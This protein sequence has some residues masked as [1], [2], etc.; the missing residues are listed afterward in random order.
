M[1]NVRDARFWLQKRRV[2]ESKYLEELSQSKRTTVGH[3]T[4]IHGVASPY[5][6]GVPIQL[7]GTGIVINL[8]GTGSGAVP[9]DLKPD[10]TKSL[11]RDA[12]FTPSEVKNLYKSKNAAAVQVL[13][14]LDRPY[15][16]GDHLDA[17]LRILDGS[18]SLEGGVLLPVSLFMIA[19]KPT[20]AKSPTPGQF[21]PAK[22]FAEASGLVTADLFV[23]KA[24]KDSL[25][26][27]ITIVE[28][29]T[30]LLDNWDF[31]ALVPADNDGRFSL[32][33]ELLFNGVFSA[34]SDPAVTRFHDS[35]VIKLRIP[36][37]Y[38]DD[39]NRFY[40]V[41]NLM[42]AKAT[43]SWYKQDR[44]KKL[45][46]ELRSK[47]VQTRYLAA[48]GLVGMQAP[49]VGVLEKAL[50]DP[51]PD[52]RLEVAGAL[53]PLGQLS[54]FEPLKAIAEGSDLGRKI[55]A[56][57]ILGRLGAPAAAP[58]IEKFLDD[59]NP[60]VVYSAAR[61]LGRIGSSARVVV[62]K[63][64]LWNLN[65]APQVEKTAVL[66]GCKA[67]R[68]ILL[69]GEPAV[70]GQAR[71][72]I[73]FMTVTHESGNTELFYEQRLPDG[74]ILRASS[75]ANVQSLVETFSK[76]GASFSQTARLISSLVQKGA[77]SAVTDSYMD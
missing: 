8:K 47:D 15:R 59:P 77:V 50:S 56:I 39:W 16:T 22:L 55:S 11:V 40:F 10:L 53:A 28:Q 24:V 33:L 3:E 54:I 7:I 14:F 42:D 21:V 6:T 34:G 17:T 25:P 76:A 74:R 32:Y 26:P 66:F 30:K 44:L 20:T 73:G 31:F 58:F 37:P 4:A 35:P 18:T 72:T 23:P 36:D 46:Q 69:M 71:E 57:Y 9:D 13:A 43:S 48:C 63:G 2:P 19:E 62:V 68:T 51:D 67:P 70:T 75:P 45:S 52:V 1:M 64:P 5:S 38:F 29:G 27:N 49:G 61:A 65:L 12:H 60:S 41:V